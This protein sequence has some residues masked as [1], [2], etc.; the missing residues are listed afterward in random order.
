MKSTNVIAYNKI[1]TL[2]D[3]SLIFLFS[4]VRWISNTISIFEFRDAFVFS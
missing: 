2:T 1:H 4:T 3:I